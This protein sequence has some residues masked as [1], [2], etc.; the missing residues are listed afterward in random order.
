MKHY[1]DVKGYTSAAKVH[2]AHNGTTMCR[3]LSVYMEDNGGGANSIRIQRLY[4]TPEPCNCRACFKALEMSLRQVI[5]KMS[6]GHLE[7]LA[8]HLTSVT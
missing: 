2:L 6:G 7:L 3:K 1:R 5:S 8:D 4:E